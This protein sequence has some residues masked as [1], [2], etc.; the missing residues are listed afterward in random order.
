[1]HFNCLC[2]YI[3]LTPTPYTQ[4]QPLHYFQ[5]SVVTGLAAC[6]FTAHSQAAQHTFGMCIMYTYIAF[7]GDILPVRRKYSD[8]KQK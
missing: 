3:S 6:D 5:N 8:L 4:F 1:M 7:S 2:T